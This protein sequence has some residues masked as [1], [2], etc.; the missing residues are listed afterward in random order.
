MNYG[1]ECGREG[2][3]RMEWSE[4]G[5]WDKCNSIINKYIKIIII[6]IILNCQGETLWSRTWFSQG[7]AYPLHSGCADP[8]NFPKYGRLYCIICSCGGL[9]SWSPLKK[10]SPGWCGSVDWVLACE[11][12]GHWF[13]SQAGHMPGLQAR[14]PVGGVWEAT[15]HWCFSPSLSSSLPFSLKIN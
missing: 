3:W 10:K 2:V 11:S 15:T 12:K 4:G 14:S 13:Y 6:I 5:K 7:K 1:G 9:H 8:C